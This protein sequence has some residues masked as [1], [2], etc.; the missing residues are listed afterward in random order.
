MSP[1]ASIEVLIQTKLVFSSNV[2]H[3]VK[4]TATRTENQIRFSEHT[5]IVK[6]E[7]SL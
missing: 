4:K 2:V 6:S 7:V 1:L 5:Q 3:D